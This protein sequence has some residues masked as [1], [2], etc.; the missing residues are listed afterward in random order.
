MFKLK[1]GISI[2]LVGSRAE[3]YDSEE[4]GRAFPWE[5]PHVLFT[6]EEVLINVDI[7]IICKAL[8]VIV[9]II[10]PTCSADVTGQVY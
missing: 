3:R 8:M 4:N 9:V 6:V 1:V 7:Y 5:L 2:Q 10:V